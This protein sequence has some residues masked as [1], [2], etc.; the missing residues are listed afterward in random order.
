MDIDWGT[1]EVKF[2]NGNAQYQGTRIKPVVSWSVS[3][4]GT[5]EDMDYL[6]DFFNARRGQEDKFYFVVEGVQELVR[7]GTAKLTPTKIRE[8]Q[9]TVGYKCDFSLVRVN[10]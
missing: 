6:L 1:R 7:F 8:L 5:K 10:A 9:N 2:E 4:G 3:A